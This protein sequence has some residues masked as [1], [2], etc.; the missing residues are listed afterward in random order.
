MRFNVRWIADYRQGTYL[1][2]Q[3]CPVFDGMDQGVAESLHTPLQFQPFPVEVSGELTILVG[4]AAGIANT[5]RDP[6]EG[7]GWVVEPHVI[8]R[9]VSESYGRRPRGQWL[10]FD[11][12][13]KHPLG[14]HERRWHDWEREDV[15]D[16]I[17]SIVDR[18]DEHACLIASSH[19]ADHYNSFAKNQKISSLLPGPVSV[20]LSYRA[21]GEV[22][23]IAD[24]VHGVLSATGEPSFLKVFF[25]KPDL[26]TGRWKPQL[27]NAVRSTD[28][29]VPLLTEDYLGGTA[30][31]ELE[32]AESL[33][34]ESVQIIPVL[35]EGSWKDYPRFNHL[36]GVQ[37]PL[38]SDDEL[39]AAQTS[40]LKSYIVDAAIRLR[41][42]NE[43]G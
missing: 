28:V 27:E 7:V 25:D 16:E 41:W 22:S 6:V 1:S 36:Q 37:I 30:L 24:R 3:Y 39:F 34:E 38:N 33:P 29:F 35:I 15:S 5:H 4:L 23:A 12:F 17:A 14:L 9:I 43:S 32:I 11:F 42:P 8:E 40:R 19:W 10:R 26:R 31:W 21:G 18:L 2:V 13:I 20:F